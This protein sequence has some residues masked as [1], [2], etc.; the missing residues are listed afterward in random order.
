MRFQDYGWPATIVSNG[1]AEV[2]AKRAG[3]IDKAE[4]Q[5]LLTNLVKSPVA[6]EAKDKP[7]RIA[8][9]PQLSNSLRKALQTK[10]IDS[11]DS[12]QGGLRQAMKYLERDSVEYT[13][14]LA[15]QGDKLQAAQAQ[16]TLTAALALQDPVWGGFYQYS[17]HSDWQHPHV[18]KIMSVQAG[19]L[20]LY[21][22]AFAQNKIGRAHV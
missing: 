8:S 12:A 3:Y 17:T 5:N 22:L 20:R 4:L 1:N 6:E 9:S 16:Q 19:Y 21:A 13:L 11:Y 2:L 10:H 15:Q 7:I 14:L 18:E